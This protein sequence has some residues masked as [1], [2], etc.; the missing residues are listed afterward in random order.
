MNGFL[1]GI[2]KNSETV[3]M[4][5]FFCA[6][7]FS[8]LFY[9]GNFGSEFVPIMGNLIAMLLQIALWLIYPLLL[10]LGKKEAAR[11]VIKPISAFWIFSFL[12]E[13]LSHTTW[14][15][16]GFLPVGIAA[17][18]FSLLIACGVI[19]A[20]VFLGLGLWKKD[21]VKKKV[22]FFI[23][24]GMLLLLL[25]LFSLTAAL[26]EAYKMGWND[27]FDIITND[28]VLPFAM[29]FV[30]IAYLF[31]EK[32]LMLERIA[33]PVNSDAEEKAVAA[34]PAAAEKPVDTE[35]VAGKEESTEAAS[36]AK[37]E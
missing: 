28:L 9:V 11:T 22:A 15:M 24:S 33:S 34:E 25:V 27:Y 35:P 17:G 37:E 16:K 12:F 26:Y 30:L 5:L 7:A 8:L 18:V 13:L 23:F 6:S 21:I 3:A 4:I 1:N 20:T 2:K 14:A 29:F 32:E 10:A 36:L 19:T 31:E